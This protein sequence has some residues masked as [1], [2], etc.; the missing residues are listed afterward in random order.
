[1]KLIPLLLFGFL[2]GTELKAQDTDPVVLT[3]EGEDVHASEFMYIYSKNNDN[4]SFDKDSLDSYMELFINYK[5][6]HIFI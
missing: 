1:M 3:I 2:F 4:V 5:L 6:N